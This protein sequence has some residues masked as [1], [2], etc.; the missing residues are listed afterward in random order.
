MKHIW[1]VLILLLIPLTAG[2][3]SQTAAT[4][5][6]MTHDSFS[7]STGVIDAFE[8]ANH[9]KVVFLKSGDAGEATNKAILAKAAPLADVF[10]GIDNTLLSRGLQAGIYEA[11]ASPQLKDIPAEFQLD[12]QD[13]ALP[14]DFGDVCI[15]YDKSY[16]AARDLAI[17]QRLE[18]L[19]NPEY[20][21]LLVVENPAISST[22]LDFLL[23]TV[24]HFGES[25][26]L[27]Y[28]AGLRKN[29]VVIVDD[30]NTAYYTNFSGS[31]GHGP[32]PMVVSYGT[33]PVAELVNANPPVSVSPV[34]T[35]HGPGTCYRQVEFVGILKGTHKLALAEKFVD[36]ML[37]KQFQE[38]IPLQMYMYPVNSNAALPASFV[39]Y[40][41][42]A[43][44]PASL[45]P[46][47]ISAERDSWIAA[48]TST[49]LR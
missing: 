21:G 28:W 31:S 22:G 13:R 39:T 17:P 2:C 32:D 11:Y 23:A 18:D 1:M 34:A 9:V 8:Q 37:G 40:A 38:D 43:V 41:Q 3:G 5:T 36:F 49:M 19:L 29:G 44:S 27:N 14:V 24:A 35:I 10:Y 25:G 45:D 47:L 12:P 7:V 6:V 48:W 42:H 15:T 33:D 20:K 30:W 46:A 4:L 16:F 26:Y